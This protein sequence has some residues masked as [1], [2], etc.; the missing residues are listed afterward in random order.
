MSF[1]DHSQLSLRFSDV[2]DSKQAS[3]TCTLPFSLVVYL[4]TFYSKAF[5]RKNI[6]TTRAFGDAID[7]IQTAKGANVPEQGIVPVAAKMKAAVSVV[8]VFRVK[9]LRRITSILC[10]LNPSWMMH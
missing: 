1:R 4:D 6:L 10:H 3:F 5:I 8:S 2:A 7:A 9:S